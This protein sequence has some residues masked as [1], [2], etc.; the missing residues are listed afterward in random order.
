MST[1]AGTVGQEHWGTQSG[2]RAKRLA[3]FVDMV[4]RVVAERGLCRIVDLGG[5][6][7]YWL[8]L[9]DVWRGRPVEITTVNLRAERIQ[10]PRFHAIEG[11]CR[12][13]PQ[14][15]DGAFDIVHSNSV[16]E[17]V[18]RWNDMR[19]MANE[20]RR[21]APRYFVQTPNYWFPLEPH[22][23]VPFFHWL[24]EPLRYALV[25][26]RGCGAFPRAETPDD[27][28]RFLEDSILVDAKRMAVLFPDAEIQRE[29]VFGLAKSLIAVR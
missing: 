29:R 18:G 2:Y 22:F 4:D 6:A 11:D 20:V 27:A 19:A 28:M 15:R 17:H 16:L 10:D 21:L 3:R 14:F 12:A 25:R 5:N 1:L 9:E 24:P 13:M 8:D 26:A 7:E 23:R